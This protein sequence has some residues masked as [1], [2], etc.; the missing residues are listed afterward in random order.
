MPPN[1]NLLN[2]REAADFLR[3]H[4]ETNRRLARKGK[5]P[6]YKVGRQW[7]IPKDALVEWA[8]AHGLR[9][10]ASRV[11]IVDDE[12]V[13]RESLRLILE[14]DGYSVSVAPDGTAALAQMGQE[15]PDVV[16]LDLQMPV[17]DGPTT[18]RAIRDAHGG[19]PVIIVTG[20][21]DSDLMTS[22][23]ECAPFMM[24]PKPVEPAQLLATIRLALN[25]SQP[26]AGSTG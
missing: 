18:L 6:R 14:G 3:V 21:P 12:R 20:Y 16:L 11:L 13:I 9:S 26:G 10:E 1:R 19:V 22:A 23:L 15:L 7:R 17:M 24:L 25:G 4:V 5:L 2:T 8:T